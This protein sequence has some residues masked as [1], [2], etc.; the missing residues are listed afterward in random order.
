MD[1]THLFLV[2]ATVAISGLIV[3]DQRDRRAREA[4]FQALL[5]RIDR[6]LERISEHTRHTAELAYTASQT[7]ARNEQLTLAVLGRL[8][9]AQQA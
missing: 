6:A 4:E 2:L 8:P 5:E 3:W 1:W 7:A 9:G